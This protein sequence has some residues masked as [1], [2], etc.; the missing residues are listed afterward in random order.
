MIVKKDND[1]CVTFAECVEPGE[2]SI[3]L[4]PYE[5]LTELPDPEVLLDIAFK[6][7]DLKIKFLEFAEKTKAI[8]D[9]YKERENSD[10]ER[11]DRV[12]SMFNEAADKLDEIRTMLK[13]NIDDLTID[14]VEQIKIEVRRLRKNTI[15][16]ILYVMLS[17]NE[18]IVEITEG[19]VQDCGANEECLKKAFELCKP[20]IFAPDE[21]GFIKIEGL[22]NNT[23]VMIMEMQGYN[24]TCKI[25]NYSRGFDLPEQ[26]IIPYCEGPLLEYRTSYS[27][28]KRLETLTRAPA[29]TCQ[30][31]DCCI[32]YGWQWIN[33]NCSPLE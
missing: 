28:S 15:K 5:R 11:F 13:E 25:P 29:S 2:E 8:A 19:E 23:C 27:E 1:G 16:N 22:E 24:M 3:G 33:D 14:D 12:S 31:E 9:F 6:L 32:S 18:D 10:Y 26:E 21:T 4:A 7:E 17:S 20:A 30:I